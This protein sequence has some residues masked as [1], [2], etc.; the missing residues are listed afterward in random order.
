MLIAAPGAGSAALRR[1]TDDDAE[2]VRISPA[3][4]VGLAVGSGAL[5]YG[6]WRFT[7]WFDTAAESALRKMR[8]PFPRAVMGAAIGAWYL[9]TETNRG[10]PEAV[11]GT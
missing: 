11:E 9:A 2:A 8:V 10:A 1:R 6:S 7:W 3:A 4:R 5:V